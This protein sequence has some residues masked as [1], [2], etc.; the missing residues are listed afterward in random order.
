MPTATLALT[1]W[2]GEAT[3]I[4]DRQLARQIISRCEAQGY[5]G[6]TRD[7]MALEM[8]IGAMMACVN[9]NGIPTQFSVGAMLVSTR[10]FAWIEEV[11]NSKEGA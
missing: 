6:K 10:G 1:K 8:Y 9:E 7:K 4:T 3:L 11:A 2:S 5:K